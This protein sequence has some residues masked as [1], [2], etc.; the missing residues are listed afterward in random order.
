MLGSL[1]VVLGLIILSRLVVRVVT[2]TRDHG[3]SI[4]IR[5]CQKTSVFVHQIEDETTRGILRMTSAGE[6]LRHLNSRRC[7]MLDRRI[8]HQ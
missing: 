6:Q 5:S 2:L 1:V 7:R 4:V 3:L 8:Q